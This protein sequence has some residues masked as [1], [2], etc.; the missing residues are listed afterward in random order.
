MGKLGDEWLGIAEI[1]SDCWALQ[2]ELGGDARVVFDVGARHG[3]VTGR[4]TEMFPEAIVYAF[5]PEGDNFKNLLKRIPKFLGSAK[6][7][8]PFRYAIL[9]Y[10]GTTPFHVHGMSDVHSVFES[11]Q[12]QPKSLKTVEVPAISLD[13]FCSKHKIERVDVLKIDTEGAELRVLQ[14]ASRLLREN[15]VG[16]I[17]CEM[18]YYPHCKGMSEPWEVSAFLDSHGWGLHSL[19]GKT[20]PGY[21]FLGGDA[22]FLKR[23]RLSNLPKRSR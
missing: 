12:Y 15:R 8:K 4:Y 6:R 13:E 2:K 22:I 3:R 7:V 14:G 20:N 19:W 17:Y 10:V 5:E 1:P 23:E 21:R 16:M 11:T 18:S 9:D